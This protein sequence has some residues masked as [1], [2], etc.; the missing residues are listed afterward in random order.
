[1]R[2]PFAVGAK[3]TAE[4]AAIFIIGDG[5]LGLLQPTRHVA[6][7][8]SQWT[9]VDVLVRSFDGRPARRRVYGLFQ[10]AAGLGLA[11]SLTI[12]GRQETHPA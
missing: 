11:Y 9:G 2:S 3:R 10:I 4:M 7:W 6:L 12:R 5:M 8:R 1:M